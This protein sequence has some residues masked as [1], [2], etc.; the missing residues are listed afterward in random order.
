MGSASSLLLK[1]DRDGFLSF[2][3]KS[4][5]TKPPLTK[6]EEKLY[7]EYL[8]FQIDEWTVSQFAVKLW[9]V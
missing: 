4:V 2:V 7:L 3:F 1:R 5:L 6:A 8:F 9:L